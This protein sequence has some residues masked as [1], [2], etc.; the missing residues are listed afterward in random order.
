MTTQETRAENTAPIFPELFRDEVVRIETP[1][2]W[3]RWPTAADAE[4]LHEIASIEAVACRTATWPHPFPAGEALRRIEQ[5][6]ARNAAGDDLVLALALKGRPQ[7]LVGLL[8]A[9]REKGGKALVV[10]YLLAVEHQGY[11]LM[12]EAVRALVG[13][14]FRYTGCATIKGASG[15]ANI[16]S[17]RVLEKAG[18][19]HTG[20][21]LHA[22]PAR[23]AAV[24]CDTL[25][26]KRD[27]WLSRPAI[28][29][30]S[31]AGNPAKEMPCGQAA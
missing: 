27:D 17:Q 14:V 4:A 23:P 25:E 31:P 16:A 30:V 10:G 5:A 13:N 19:R 28:R 15:A 2:L 26:L 18:F 24:P 29:P 21:A 6:R 9:G 11:G 22:A 7:R 12:T 20:K 8:G 3:L 1:R